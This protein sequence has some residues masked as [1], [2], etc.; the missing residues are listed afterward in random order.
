MR[1]NQWLD[2]F[3]NEKG[4]DIEQGF[5]VEGPTGPNHM[6]YGHVITAIK[7]ASANEQTGIKNMLVRI[8]FAN[9]DVRHYLR[10]LAQA[11]AI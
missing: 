11:I 10:H 7:G 2:I 1:F 3:I 4:I 5:T 8:D 6:T 9:G